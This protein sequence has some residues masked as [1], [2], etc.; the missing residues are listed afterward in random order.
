MP[1]SNHTV[2][3]AF[4]VNNPVHT[5]VYEWLAKQPDTASELVRDAAI[6][7]YGY[8]AIEQSDLPPDQKAR[9]L[10]VSN[11]ELTKFLQLNNSIASL[12]L[13]STPIDSP[14]SPLPTPPIDFQAVSIPSYEEDEHEE[15]CAEVEIDIEL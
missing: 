1:S 2:A 4:K 12:G 6:A 5:L 14:P 3:V 8:R 9:A 15:D 10:L 7:I 11:A 13:P